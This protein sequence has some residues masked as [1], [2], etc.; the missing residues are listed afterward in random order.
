MKLLSLTRVDYENN[1]CQ[2][3]NTIIDAKLQGMKY[4]FTDRC[5]IIDDSKASIG[6]YRVDNGKAKYYAYSENTEY[7]KEQN[8]YVLIPQN[9]YTKDATILG[10]VV[11]ENEGVIESASP[12]NDI[13]K[14]RTY[15]SGQDFE[16]VNRGIL[17][18]D[19]EQQFKE[20]VEIN[21]ISKKTIEGFTALA[22]EVN[23]NTLFPYDFITSGE[24]GIKISFYGVGSSEQI[25]ET[26]TFSSNNFIGDIY[27]L[28]GFFTQCNI[29]NVFYFG[30]ENF[31]C[32][33]NYNEADIIIKVSLFQENNFKYFDNIKEQ[34]VP[35]LDDDGQTKL[36]DNITIDSLKIHFGR[37]KNEFSEDDNSSI[38]DIFPIQ[39]Q[40][41]DGKYHYTFGAKWF[42]KDTIYNDDGEIEDIQYNL[43]DDIPSIESYFNRTLG[44]D[45]R[46][47]QWFQYNENVGEEGAGIN[48]E[49]TNQFNF[50]C[51]LDNLNNANLKIKCQLKDSFSSVDTEIVYYSN[52]IDCKYEDSKFIFKNIIDSQKPDDSQEEIE[53][54]G[55]TIK[56]GTGY[57]PIQGEDKP[58]YETREISFGQAKMRFCANG[59]IQ[60]YKNGNWKQILTE[61]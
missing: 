58:Y 13:A 50:K 51:A 9:D 11:T 38:V 43:F 18:N 1:F 6:K 34:F 29:Y 56:Y 47:L 10:K 19:P 23:M 52:T 45:Y 12:L 33:A 59:D 2:A 53:T 39:A 36:N 4:D 20:I 21:N 44:N 46:V 30:D 28:N 54:N 37:F 42:F 7:K 57:Q 25:G 40:I 26:L 16:F 31:N 49:N 60:I 61:V 14:F 8:V 5:T 32:F 27:N 24:Y 35:Y 55:V 48:W 15:E 22:L 17:A 3:V 41:S